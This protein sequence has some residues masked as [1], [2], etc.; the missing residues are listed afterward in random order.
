MTNPDVPD[1]LARKLLD[2]LIYAPI[3]LTLDA[4]ALAPDLARRGRQH[5]AAARQIGELAVKLGIKRLDE[6]MAQ[7]SEPPNAET[8]QT[9]APPDA[10]SGDQP[11][12]T[13]PG[14]TPTTPASSSH[15]AIVDY[16]LLAAS[17]VVKR[18]DALAPTELEAVRLYESSTRDRRTIL[19]KIARLQTDH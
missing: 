4:E 19:H 10:G 5:C 16:D 1:D 13:T 7:I 17:Q 12:Q 14:T 9:P 2:L 18:L 15:L 6:V 11:D 3:G 8:E